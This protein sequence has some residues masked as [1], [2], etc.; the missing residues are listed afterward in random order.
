MA[1]TTFKKYKKE[2]QCMYFKEIA[3]SN[4]IDSALEIITFL[5]TF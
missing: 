3:Q 1:D 4:D 5:S 2:V